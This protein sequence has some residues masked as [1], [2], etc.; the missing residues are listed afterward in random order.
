M[1]NT[2]EKGKKGQKKK[3]LY[4]IKDI[5][6]LLYIYHIVLNAFKHVGHVCDLVK[7]TQNI[8][9]FVGVRRADPS[10][11]KTVQKLLGFSHTTI[12]TD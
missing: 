5:F 2:L 6:G 4:D 8:R 1:I 11:K 7:F 10:I 12:S 3:A 9:M